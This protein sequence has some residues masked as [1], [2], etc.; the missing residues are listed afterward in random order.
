MIS[1]R[2]TPHGVLS[3]A[4]KLI[5]YLD[6]PTTTQAGI[7]PWSCPVISFG[8]LS[9]PQLATIGINPSSR[10]FM[11]ASGNELKGE[12]RR[13]P[14]L[15]S[16]GLQTWA[17]A[18][19]RHLESILESYRSYF[20]SNPYDV[21]FK[22]LDSILR[23]A[24]VS[25]YPPLFNACHLDLVPYATLSKWADL[26]NQ[27]R[28]LLL[29]LAGDT[30]AT[31]LRDSSV[32]TL[33]LNGTSVVRGFQSLS[34]SCLTA[35]VVPDWFLGRASG[36]KVKGIAYTGVIS[37]VCGVPLD[38]DL[39][40]LGFNHNLQSSFGVTKEVILAIGDWIARMIEERE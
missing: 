11:D 5:D 30:L 3:A 24:R 2:R 10:E 15:A 23:G 36:H 14:T 25:Y 9:T 22:K 19:A 8:D 18:D 34:G 6:R 31:I 40:I 32:R 28:S 21:W 39:S 4:A 1:P 26:P 29:T 37:D 27:Q 17:D 12:L 13:F 33:I 20:A 7:I 35:E 16:L 38:R